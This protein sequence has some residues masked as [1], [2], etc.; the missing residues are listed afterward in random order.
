MKTDSGCPTAGVPENPPVVGVL[1]TTKLRPAETNPESAVDDSECRRRRAVPAPGLS[2]CGRSD[3]R[4]PCRFPPA[5]AA[6]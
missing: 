4:H 1:P 6:A 5:P 3:R 2:R